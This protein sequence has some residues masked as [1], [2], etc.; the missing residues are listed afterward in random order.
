[1]RWLM[2]HISWRIR[3]FQLGIET[4]AWIEADDLGLPEGGH[5][6]E[7]ITYAGFDSI[8]GHLDIRPDRDVFLDYGSGKGRAIVLAGLQ[9]FKRVIGIEYSSVLCDI[10]NKNLAIVASKLKAGSVEVIQGD[11]AKYALPDEVTVIYL[12]NSFNGRVLEHVHDNIRKSLEASPRGMTIFTGVPQGEEDM[13]AGLPWLPK[14][15]QLASKYFTGVNIVVYRIP[16]PNLENG[17]Q[18]VPDI[19][20]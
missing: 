14:P 4:E 3:E 18:V 15:S 13:M 8:L 5:C 17:S 9:P 11:A 16:E 10:A 6:Y 7:P 2:G 12:W 19:T 20:N 1:M